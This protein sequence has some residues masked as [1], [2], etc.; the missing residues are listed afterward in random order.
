MNEV[1]NEIDQHITEIQQRAREEVLS[2]SNSYENFKN[3]IIGSYP[4]M[5][6]LPS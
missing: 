6:Y 5:Q 2:V 3:R 4:L 1:E